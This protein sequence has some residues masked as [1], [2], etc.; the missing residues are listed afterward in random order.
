MTKWMILAFIGG[1]FGTFLMDW[2]KKLLASMGLRNGVSV[3][4]L[5]RW[6]L[7]FLQGTPE[8][9]DIS[10]SPALPHENSLGWF[11]HVIIGG[12]CVALLYPIF[13]QMT[14]ISMPENHMLSGVLFGLI[15]VLIPGLFLLP[16]FGWGTLGLKAPNAHHPL[17][18]SILCHLVFGF[19]LGLVMTFVQIKGL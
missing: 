10:K 11:F 12:G 13:F 7:G 9:T 3:P 6:F 5:G 1:I 2:L 4:L 15:T 19:G 16:S 8:H 18:V 14:L 17:L